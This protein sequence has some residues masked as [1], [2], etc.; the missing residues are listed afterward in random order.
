[1]A[2]RF[3]EADGTSHV[4]ALAYQTMFVVLSGFVGSVGLSS[5]LDLPE[6]RGV[7][8]ELGR[9]LSPG[10]AGRLIRQAAGQGASG[11][12]SAAVFGLGAALSAGT[13]AM[14]QIER[15]ANRLAGSDEDRSAVRRYVVAFLLAASV[16]LLLAA[17]GLVLGAGHAVA[18]G[19]GWVDGI[20]TV[21]SVLRW[22]IGVVAVTAAV[23]LLYRAAPRRRLRPRRA[24]LG[25]SLVAVALWVTFTGLL[26]LYFSIQTSSPYRSLLSIVALLLWS[27]LTSLALHLGMATACE[28]AGAPPPARA[29]PDGASQDG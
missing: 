6:L 22:P 3:L 8:E 23:M 17:A 1:M 12:T 26:S 19:F 11:G 28:I 16:G 24:I 20:G 21:W 9:S 13:L 25:G 2:R 15:S 18:T 5:L 27:M 14:A 7:V 29:I 10:P 4:R